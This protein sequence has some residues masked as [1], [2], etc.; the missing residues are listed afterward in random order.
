MKIAAIDIG[1]NAIKAKVF[2][3]SPTSIDFIDGI[4]TPVR[5]GTEVYKFG[6]LSEET[7]ELLVTTIKDYQ[8]YFEKNNVNRFEIVATSAFR[9]TSNS[10]DARRIVENEIEHPI[11]IISGLEEANLIRFHPKAENDE[12][13]VFVDVGGGST[14]FFFIENN[15]IKIKSFQLGAVRL[16]YNDQLSDEWQ[17]LSAWLTKHRLPN[18]LIGL[19][20]NIRSFLNIHKTKSIQRNE[21]MNYCKLL[22][23]IPVEDKINKFNISHDRADVI[24]N[25]MNI[26]KF[27]VEKSNIKKIKATKW[28]VSDSIAVKLFHEL[29][30]RE[31]KIKNKI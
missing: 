11:R 15:K 23:N 1:T 28:G 29:Y 30:S 21:F 10:E 2:E 16:M 18:K 14:E 27:I 4:R 9:D 8:K 13:K 24:D 19:G 25:A 5:L 7:L 26:F 22:M 12:T 3:T 6:F 17:K 20:G 31:I